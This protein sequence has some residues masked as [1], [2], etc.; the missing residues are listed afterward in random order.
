[1]EVGKR[2]NFQQTKENNNKKFKKNNF[3]QSIQRWSDSKWS[4]KTWFIMIYIEN[5]HCISLQTNFGG[6]Q[7]PTLSKLVLQQDDFYCKSLSKRQCYKSYKYIT[8][9]FQKLWLLED[10]KREKIKYKIVLIYWIIVQVI[11]ITN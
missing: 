2:G 9:N 10:I 4:L 7:I 8:G 11:Y 3:S 1:M 6:K 5:V